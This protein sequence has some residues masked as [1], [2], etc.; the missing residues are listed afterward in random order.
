MLASH[1]DLLASKL[2]CKC[3]GQSIFFS[4]LTYNLYRV[5]SVAVTFPRRIKYYKRLVD[6]PSYGRFLTYSCAKPF[7]DCNDSGGLIDEL[8]L[9]KSCT[10]CKRET[11]MWNPIHPVVIEVRHFSYAT[12]IYHSKYFTICNSFLFNPN[13]S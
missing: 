11:L 12:T 2:I 8:H 7:R 1:L 9:P 13:F 6:L 4:F 5:F 10:Y 3:C